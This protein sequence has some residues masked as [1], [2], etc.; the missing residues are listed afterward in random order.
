MSRRKTRPPLRSDGK[1]EVIYLGNVEAQD[2]TPPPLKTRPPLRFP[3]PPSAF[4]GSP[5]A[6][7]PEANAAWI[8]RRGTTWSSPIVAS[9]SGS[10]PNW[11][12][13][14]D[15]TLP[16]GPTGYLVIVGWWDSYGG[17]DDQT[18]FSNVKVT[19]PGQVIRLSY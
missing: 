1:I 3:T 6:G 12:G 8:I 9:G 19:T 11:S 15:V 16:V 2:A 13:V 4:S 7:D 17:N 14:N 5:C 18:V 10:C